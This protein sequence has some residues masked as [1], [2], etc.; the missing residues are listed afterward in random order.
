MVEALSIQKLL[1]LV[2]QAGSFFEK[3]DPA[4]LSLDQNVFFHSCFDIQE[5][6]D[7]AGA[8]GGTQSTW[9][10]KIIKDLKNPLW[11]KCFP[12]RLKT[13][14]NVV[15]AVDFQ[16]R[17][18]NVSESKKTM[19]TINN[20][21]KHPLDECLESLV[22]DLCAK[23]DKSDDLLEGRKASSIKSVMMKLALVI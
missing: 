17:S 6:D 14:R 3:G 4:R 10:S 16:R 8:F 9:C 15:S 5:F 18:L 22:P 19:T 21:G 12:Q 11:T 1:S 20:T 23:I 7:L 2:K 13:K